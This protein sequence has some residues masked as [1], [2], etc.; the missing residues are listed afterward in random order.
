MPI[1]KLLTNLPKN[2]I[3]KDFVT[4]IVPILSRTVN[5]P[6]SKFTCIVSSDCC[7]SVGGDDSKPGAV[8]SLES[9][10][11]LGVDANKVI[12]KE[13]SDFVERE[14]GIEQD[15]FILTFYDLLPYNVSKGGITM[16]LEKK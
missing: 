5:K 1:L 4:K 15:R 6:P 7:L 10:G 13:I 16:D 8:A 11:N 3:P 12:T 14:L 9:I 2:Q